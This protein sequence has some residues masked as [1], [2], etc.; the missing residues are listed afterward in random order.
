MKIGSGIARLELEEEA[1]A[2]LCRVL[3]RLTKGRRIQKR[4]YSLRESGDVLWEV[5]E[6]LD[7]TLV[8]AEIELAAADMDVELPPWL[9]A[10]MDREVTDEPE[11]ANAHLAR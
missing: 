2:D 10:V 9:R 7:R 1:D 3:W 6:F 8:V 5:D 11:Y 4:R